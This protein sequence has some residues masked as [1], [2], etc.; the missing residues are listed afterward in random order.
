MNFVGRVFNSV[1]DLYKDINP[2]QLCGANDVIVIRTRKGLESTGFYARFGDV[3]S[4]NNS[5]E[6]ILTVNDKVVNVET[7]LDKDGNLFFSLHS[8]PRCEVEI[9]DYSTASGHRTIK[10]LIESS[11]NYAYLLANHEALAEALIGRRFIFSECLHKQIVPPGKIIDTFNANQTHNFL[12]GDTVVVG[13]YKTVASNPD[14]LMS[15]SLFSELYF[16]LER[17]AARDESKTTTGKY[18]IKHLLR[19][20]AKPK[21]NQSSTEKQVF[22]P[23]THLQE[24]NLRP[25]P[26][27]CVYRLSGTHIVLTCTIYLWDENDK[28]V[29]SDIDGTITKSDLIGYIYGAMGRDWTHAGIA[30]LYTK[31]Q[32]NG[33]QIVYLSSRPIGHIGLTRAYLE[34]VEQD[35]ARLPTGPVILFPG[36][37]LSAIYRE[38]VIGPEEHKITI[39]SEI[40]SLLKTG[41]VFAGFGNK[42]SD[43]TAYE[44]CEIDPGRIFIVNPLGEISTGKNG[45]VKLTHQTLLH[46]VDGVFPA[47]NTLIWGVPQMYRGV[48]WWNSASPEE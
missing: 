4:F 33:Y 22:L 25:G 32:E 1:S 42:E 44:L 17:R 48:T 6:V 7:R 30:P 43:R 47:V 40:K 20:R 24:M 34:R 46:M 18:L 45:L 11:G 8:S 39:I 38:V 23:E 27:K 13:L 16:C 31:I 19:K 35:G 5:K 10:G 15:F 12:G 14:F 29:I 41:E 2:S 21:Q 3:R 26:N 37:L 36:R 9:L 28:I